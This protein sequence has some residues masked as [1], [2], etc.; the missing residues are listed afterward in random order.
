MCT[1]V[2]VAE[3][4]TAEKTQEALRAAHLYYM[5]DLTMEAIAS[6]LGTSRSSVSRLLKSAR[7]SGLVDIQIKSPLDQAT[8]VAEGLHRR[9]GVVAHVVPV[10]DQTSDV[11]RLERVALSAARTITPYVDSNMVIGVAWGSTLSAVSRSLVPKPTHNSVVVQL[12]GAANTRTTGI[13]Y[14]SEILRRFGQAYTAAIQQFPVPAFF[15]DPAT[16]RALWRERSTKRVLELQASMDLV[17]FGVGSRDARVPS[18]VYSG[19]YLEQSDHDSLDA[20][21]VVGDVATVFY[22]ADGSSTDI[23]LN[24]RGTGPDL[25]T[26]RRAPRRV[27][28][29]AGEAKVAGVRGALAAGLATDLILDEGTARALLA[30]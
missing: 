3:L 30:S 24:A 5:Q 6:E 20:D 23:E 15:D 12:N 8:A 25:A 14:A 2:L 29:V 19:G 7:E 10:P 28:V 18:H 4:T 16:K 27:C 22:R 1:E 21:H 26:V 9:F 13:E 11:D 17:V